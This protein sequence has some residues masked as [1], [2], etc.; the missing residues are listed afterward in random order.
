MQHSVEKGLFIQENQY[1]FEAMR[2]QIFQ[3]PLQSEDVVSAFEIPEGAHESD[4]KL[5]RLEEKKK[6]DFSRTW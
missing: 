2:K 6:K 3:V 1:S 5:K 4:G